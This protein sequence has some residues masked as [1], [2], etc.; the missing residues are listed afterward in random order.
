MAD[1]KPSLSVRDKPQV[2]VAPT[3]RASCQTC[4]DKL[5]QGAQKVGMVGRSSGVSCMK[6]M[7]PDCFA[8]NMR[9]E[10]APTGRAKCNT[11]PD[12]PFIGK[13]EPRLLFRMMKTNLQEGQMAKC[14]QIYNPVNAAKLVAE[15]LALDGVT[16]TVGDIDGLPELESDAHRKWVIDALEGRAVGP[17]PVSTPPN[18]PR[19]PKKKATDAEKAPKTAPPKKKTKKVVEEEEEPEEEDE[20]DDEA[21]V[22]D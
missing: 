12:G 22:V 17:A 1:T 3:G 7:K 8:R 15:Y 10:Y 14:Q 9:V 13:G 19:A 6:W 20:D 4:G 2:V 11:D 18:K 5:E 16:L 21:D